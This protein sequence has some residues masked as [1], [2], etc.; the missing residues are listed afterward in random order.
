[1]NDPYASHTKV[2]KRLS[3]LPIKKVLE[4]GS[5][6]YSTGL[7]LDRSVFTQLEHLDTVEDDNQW[8][9][10]ITDTFKDDRLRVFKTVP[11][12]RDYDL[13]F[14]DNGTN[15]QQRVQGILTSYQFDG[16]IV[17]HDFEVPEYQ[18]AANKF[19][20]VWIYKKVKPYTAIC[21]VRGK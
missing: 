12:D 16:I 11:E 19:K 3:K 18:E 2:L 9:I 8:R 6:K 20:R 7:F 10:Y 14:V 5:G 15:I 17:I 13:I 21:K 4:L 1:M